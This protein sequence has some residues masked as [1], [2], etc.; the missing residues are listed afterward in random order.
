VGPKVQLFPRFYRLFVSFQ[1]GSK[2]PASLEKA[3]KL[4]ISY[5]KYDGLPLEVVITILQEESVKRD[6]AREGVTISIGPDA[7]QLADAEINLELRDVTL[8]ET[9]E[10][11]ADSVGL[12]VQASDTELLI[13]RKKA[14]Q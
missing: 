7:K 2:S 8:A 12:N 1:T 11:V 4:E 10:R 6:P 5:V 3:R 13:V 14:K 9:L